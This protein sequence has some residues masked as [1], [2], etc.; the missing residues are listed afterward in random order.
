MK[1]LLLLAL[2]TTPA[3]ATDL[4]YLDADVGCLDSARADRYI[5]DLNIDIASFGG[6]EVCDPQSDAKKILTDI[7]LIEEGRFNT[8]GSNL[9]IKGFVTGNYYDY[10]KRETNGMDRKN[11]IPYASAYNSGG[12]F[13]F[14]DGWA[15]SSTLGRVGTIIHEARHTEGYRHVICSA[16][17]Y[18][19]STVSGCDTSLRQGGSHGVEMEYYARVVVQGENFHPVYRSMARLMALGRSNVFFNDSPLRRREALVALEAG[20]NQA[21]LADGAKLSE[22][23]SPALGGVLKRTSFG[24]AIFTTLNAWA[25]DLYGT[26]QG[27]APIKDAYSYFKMLERSDTAPLGL[28]DLEEFD[29]ANKRYLVG[30]SNSGALVSYD[31]PGGKWVSLP[32]T[33]LNAQRLV[34]ATP[35]GRSGLFV[36]STDGSLYPFNPA[37]RRLG[38]ALGVRWPQDTVTLLK[39]GDRLL[40]LRTDGSLVELAADGS[41]QPEAVF[42][43][44]ALSQVVTSPLYDAF[45]V[46]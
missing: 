44:R 18:A 6:K 5:R 8:G 33:N 27:A 30:L 11:D 35:D 4:P 1:N 2:S 29:V 22:R 13:T 46:R 45:D 3:F 28:R 39:A 40:A 26:E 16:G 9:F 41:S 20:T 42:A 14:Q 19:G 32:T 21:L 17:P 15:Q 25:L 38:T 34:T 31:F 43:G 10:M 37:T 12:Y 36:L 7:Y 23:A 24:A